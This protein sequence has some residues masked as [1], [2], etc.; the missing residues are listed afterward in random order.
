MA[1]WLQVWSSAMRLREQLGDKPKVEI[2]LLECWCLLKKRGSTHLEPELCERTQLHCSFFHLIS[3]RKVPGIENLALATK[4]KLCQPPKPHPRRVFGERKGSQ[5]Q[6]LSSF[7]ARTVLKFLW[8]LAQSSRKHLKSVG[9]SQIINRN[10]C[11]PITWL[12]LQCSNSRIKLCLFLVAQQSQK[13]GLGLFT[14]VE[15]KEGKILV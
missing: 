14:E 9:T 11:I 12:S 1:K 13:V 4:K 7:R 10:N 6:I 5:H 15:I 3:P 8:P 2:K